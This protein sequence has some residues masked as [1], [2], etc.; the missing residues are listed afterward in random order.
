MREP[1][2]K[3]SKRFSNSF[4]GLLDSIVSA[5]VPNALGMRWPVS[6]SNSQAFSTNFY[7]ALLLDDDVYSI[8]AALM[9]AR[10]EALG[11]TDTSVWCSPILIKQQFS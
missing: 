1:L 11:Y 5:Q 2:P 7:R 8:E 3:R 4:T 9:K 6:V 10:S